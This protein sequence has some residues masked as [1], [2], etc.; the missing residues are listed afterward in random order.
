MYNFKSLIVAGL[1]LG[2][3]VISAGAHAASG[4]SA[5]G[6][7]EWHYFGGSKRM[8]RYSPLAQIDRSNVHQLKMLWTRPGLDASLTQQFPDLTPSTYL[9]GTPIMVDGVLYATDA[10][11]LVEAFDAGHRQDALGPEAG[12]RHAQRGRRAEH[13]RRRYWRAGNE[14]RIVSVRGQLS[15]RARCQDGGADRQLRRSW[16]RIARSG[17]R[18]TTLRSS[19]SMGRSSWVM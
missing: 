10:V 4:G 18:L 12:R 15:L 7:V 1:A 16:A 13:A 19:P 14:R 9:R 11:G 8:D 3:T 5:T 6:T 2:T 17:I